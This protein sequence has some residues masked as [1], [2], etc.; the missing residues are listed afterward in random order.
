MDHEISNKNLD[1]FF[2]TNMFIELNKKLCQDKEDNMFEQDICDNYATHI[3][4]N[5]YKK[6][7]TNRFATNQCKLMSQPTICPG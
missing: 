2:I 4:N 3:L 6:V 7:N 5:K 1:K